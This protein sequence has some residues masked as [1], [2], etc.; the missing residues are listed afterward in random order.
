MVEKAEAVANGEDSVL[1]EVMRDLSRNHGFG[2]HTVGAAIEVFEEAVS[3]NLFSLQ[4]L[5]PAKGNTNEE[6][7][8]VKEFSV[9]G[10]LLGLPLMIELGITVAIDNNIKATTH[11]LIGTLSD[12]SALVEGNIVALYNPNAR[13]FLRIYGEAV[14]FDGGIK[15][16]DEL[17]FDWGCERFLVVSAGSGRIALYGP[18]HGRFLSCTDGLTE[19]SHQVGNLDDRPRRSES[20]RIVDAPSGPPSIQLCCEIDNYS[21]INASDNSN[22]TI[23]Q[24]AQIHGFESAKY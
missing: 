17:P 8:E 6:G 4:V 24:V 12:K 15:T 23:F 13:S 9:P 1:V 3:S 11:H 14:D 7:G 22:L 18:S 19:A 5:A 16:I 2:E 20:F 21:L 10:R